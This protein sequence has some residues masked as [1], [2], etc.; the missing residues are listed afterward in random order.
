MK[1][2]ND[3]SARKK[4]EKIV[5]SHQQRGEEKEMRFVF[6]WV[7]SI[8]M[9]ID[10]GKTLKDTARKLLFRENE[11]DLDKKGCDIKEWADELEDVWVY[12]KDFKDWYE[13]EGMVNK[14]PFHEA[15]VA[16]EDK[17]VLTSGHAKKRLRT[18]LGICSSA[19]KRMAKKVYYCGIPYEQTKGVTR[20]YLSKVLQNTDHKD[21]SNQV[22]L[23]LFHDAIYIYKNE[24]NC[25]LLVTVLKVPPA[26]RKC[27]ERE[28]A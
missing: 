21:E 19:A 2:I 16:I 7:G 14:N 23:R 6:Q 25:I 15:D 8:E 27:V 17:E 24:K 1:L 3:E 12:G 5:Q 20:S 26:Y 22:I 10:E 18:R 28:T 13:S 9:S 11:R 4:Y